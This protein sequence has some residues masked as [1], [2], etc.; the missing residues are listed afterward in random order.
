MYGAV[1]SSV[2]P[3][4]SHATSTPTSS[5]SSP[6]SSS[7]AGTFRLQATSLL[8]LAGVCC[9]GET[10]SNTLWPSRLLSLVSS[11]CARDRFGPWAL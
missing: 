11:S 3:Q 10:A 9:S 7:M 4:H 1:H 2:S 6:T 5:V 8:L